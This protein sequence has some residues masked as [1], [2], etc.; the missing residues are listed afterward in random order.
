MSRTRRQNE[1]S[2][3]PGVSPIRRAVETLT[4]LGYAWRTDPWGTGAPLSTIQAWTALA[5]I[6]TGKTLPIALAAFDIAEAEQPLT[7]RGLF[8][9]VVSAGIFP[10][11]DTKH[12]AALGRIC[13]I[14]REHD[15]M[16]WRWLRDSLRST[17]KPSSWTG[18]ADFADTVAQAYRK[19][20]WAQQPD[21]V[22]VVVEK[23]AIAGTL[24]DLLAEYDIALSPIR[25][26]AS[27]S[28]AFDLAETFEAIKKPVHVYY[29]GDHDPS[30]RDLE[31][32][33][34]EKL[35]RRGAVVTWHRLGVDPED[36]D[37]F[38]L[39][40]LALKPG[41][42]RTQA[43][44]AQWGDRAVEL[45]ALPPTEIRRRVQEAIDQHID[46]DAWERLQALEAH[47]R[48]LWR[49][50]TDPA[51]LAAAEEAEALQ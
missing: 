5:E 16:P 21:Y 31:R 46:W 19:D 34:R 44:R 33:F 15:V 30:G 40:P 13:T 12:Y 20:L 23:D 35:A 51:A 48:D 37:A 10:S 45:D 36:I 1:A 17:S 24:A 38:D 29:L 11:T 50:V 9:R 41:D 26:Y 18:L 25:G 14:M 47:E 49:R 7:L 42:R 28:F 8:Y 4:A 39:I 22:H 2:F 43:F 6:F 3:T 27:A 32:D